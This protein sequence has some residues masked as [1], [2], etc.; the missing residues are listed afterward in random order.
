VKIT[1]DADK[2]EN[3]IYM[4][5]DTSHILLLDKENE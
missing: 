4:V 3:M 5:F 1:R 2:L